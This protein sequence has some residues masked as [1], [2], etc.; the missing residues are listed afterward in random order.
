LTT[1]L[2]ILR[3]GMG[4]IWVV[5]ALF[6]LDPANNFFGSF[7]QTASSYAASTPGPVPFPLWVAQYP[8]AFSILIASV[9]V[10][11]AAGFLT[12]YAVRIAAV[13]GSVFSLLLLW[14]QWGATFTMPGATDVGPHPLYLLVYL[15][16]YLGGAGRTLTLPEA[17][18]ALKSWGH[19][20][21][22][23]LPGPVVEAGPRTR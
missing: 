12:G 22:P 11:L 7:S 1:L 21:L 15:I 18:Q 9:T 16:L 6:I 3:L 23:A 4:V 14:T 13:V 10:F 2:E 5:N 20:A 17:V 19:R 8:L